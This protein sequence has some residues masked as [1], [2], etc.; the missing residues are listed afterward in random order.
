[1]V[2]GPELLKALADT[3]PAAAAHSLL[4]HLSSVA[5]PLSSATQIPAPTLAEW[6]GASA[7]E[8]PA[9]YRTPSFR[10]LQRACDPPSL[11]G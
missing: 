7:F 5:S 2:N 1:M 11:F 6:F 4:A 8:K 10:D 3:Q 9:S